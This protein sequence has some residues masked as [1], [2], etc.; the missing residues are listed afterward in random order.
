[1]TI[2]RNQSTPKAAPKRMTLEEYLNYDDGTDTRYELRDGLLVDMGAESDINVVIG[3]LLFSIFLQWVPYYCVRRGTEIAVSGSA[4][5]TRYP[6]LVVVTEAGAAALAGQQR[7]L[8][9]FEMPAPA[10]VVEVVSNSDTNQRSR[11]RDYIDKRREYAKREIPEY[12]I[13]DPVAAVVLVLKLVNQDYQEQRFR[14]DERLVSP[15]FPELTLSAKQV[16]EAGP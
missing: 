7:S 9:T 13:V 12:W 8:I 16:L 3:S 6:D 2:S 15:A 14:G 11:D 5:N 10:L 4:A 1:M